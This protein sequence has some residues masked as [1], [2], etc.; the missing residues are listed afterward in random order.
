MRLM[1][2][3]TKQ[4]GVTILDHS[5]ALELLVD[6]EGAV[7]GA[8]R[9]APPE[10]RSLDRAR[11]GGGDRD[12]RLRVPEQDAGLERA[13]RRRLPDGRG[14]R[15]RAQQHGVFQPYAISAGVR[16]GDQDAVLWL[17]H[18]HLRGRQRGA[19]RG[20][21]G[22]ALGDCA[23]AVAG[24]GLRAARQ[25]RR[26]DPAPRCARRSRTSSCR[27]TAPGSIRSRSAFRS[28]CGSRARCAAPAA[29]AS[30][31]TAAPP[32][33]PGLYA[34][35]DAATR[36]LICGGFTG[37]GS[38]NA[39]W[40]RCRRG[41]G[42][43]GAA[44][45]ARAA[46]PTR[47]ATLS[48]AGAVAFASR[49][50]RAFGAG[51]AGERSGRGLSVRAELFPA[52]RARLDGALARLDAARREASAADAARPVTDAAA[53]PRARPCWQPR[54]GC[55]AARL[56]RTRA[57]ACTAATTIPDQ[58]DL[59]APL[60]ELSGRARRASGPRYGRMP[61]RNYAEAAE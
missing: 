25:G 39:A 37:G 19:R 12:R 41:P 8:S 26:R 61:R 50:G 44:G 33:V 29:F 53:R 43:T 6:D 46:R 55:T 10:A 36:E 57:A 38:P 18:L 49:A 34:A 24:A 56:A 59:P 54:A 32:R 15:R 11:R 3:R 20:V 31:T 60:R 14:G 30:S 4:A 28:P 2:K 22:R 7:A 17:G 35:G 52:K 13:D 48:S 9:R 16:F 42:R 45:Y 40:G 51:R 27:S 47:R 58:D 5:P 23:G 1:R 21:Q